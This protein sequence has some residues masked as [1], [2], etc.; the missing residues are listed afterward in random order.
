MKKHKN[1]TK[2]LICPF[3]HKKLIL[4]KEMSNDYR[5]LFYNCDCTNIGKDDIMWHYDTQNGEWTFWNIGWEQVT[6]ENEPIRKCAFIF[7]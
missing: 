2:S 5:D 4:N 1:L 3:C 7:R 6:K